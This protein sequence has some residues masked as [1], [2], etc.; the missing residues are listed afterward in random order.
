MQTVK[1]C[2]ALF[3]QILK[4]QTLY[5]QKFNSSDRKD[6]IIASNLN[7]NAVNNVG[8]TFNQKSHLNFHPM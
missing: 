1:Y 5:E 6:K 3:A 7:Y 4:S 8:K 2:I